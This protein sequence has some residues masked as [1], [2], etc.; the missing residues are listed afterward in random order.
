MKQM[1]M[2]LSYYC[3]L[4]VGRGISMLRSVWCILNVMEFIHFTAANAPIL[5]STQVQFCSVQN[6]LAS[7]QENV[8]FVWASV[9]M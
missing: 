6:T 2:S 4:N 7:L 8:L 1:H 9:N 5:D 3:G